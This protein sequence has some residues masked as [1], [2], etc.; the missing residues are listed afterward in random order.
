MYDITLNGITRS[1]EF[2]MDLENH[3]LT[4]TQLIIE[5]GADNEN[6][7]VLEVHIRDR[8]SPSNMTVAWMVLYGDK[9]A[10]IDAIKDKFPMAK[11][12][13]EAIFNAFAQDELEASVCY[14]YPLDGE[15]TRI[16]KNSKTYRALCAAQL[17]SLQI[18]GGLSKIKSVYWNIRIAD[19]R[20]RIA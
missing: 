14:T 2:V 6:A 16:M 17:V 5:D 18:C 15:L 8:E 4:R 9:G 19:S 10:I 20:E 12:E 3:I 1:A 13:T 11:L 7:D